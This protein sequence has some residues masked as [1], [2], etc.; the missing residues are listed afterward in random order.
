MHACVG[1]SIRRENDYCIL[2]MEIGKFEMKQSNV[3]VDKDN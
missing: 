1:K 2:H 3:K